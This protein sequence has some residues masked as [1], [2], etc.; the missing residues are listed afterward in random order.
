V[1]PAA[2]ETVREPGHDVSG[3]RSKS[4][5]EFAKP[6]ASREGFAPEA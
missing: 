5:D 1:H 2:L 3:L 6:D 4:W